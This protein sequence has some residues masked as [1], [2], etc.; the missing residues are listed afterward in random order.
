MTPKHYSKEVPRVSSIVAFKFPF[1]GTESEGYFHKW[2]AS[3]GISV[4][5]YMK[6]AEN[7]GTFIHSKIEEFILTG[8]KYS[9]NKYKELLSNAYEF[10]EWLQLSK[11]K[12]EVYFCNDEMQGTCDLLANYNGK[13]YIID[14]KSYFIA[15]EKFWLEIPT[16]R[17]TDKLK[18]AQLQLSLYAK[19]FKVKNIAVVLLKSTGAELIELERIPNKELNKIIDEYKLSLIEE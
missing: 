9:W 14:W 19:H 13:R 11:E 6:E 7:A 3:K 16:K 1:E 4:K 18:K 8:K 12:T 17:P 15:R 2:L 10:I 5:E